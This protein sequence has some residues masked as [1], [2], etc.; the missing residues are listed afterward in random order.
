MTSLIQ[1]IGFLLICGLSSNAGE[2]N[3]KSALHTERDRYIRYHDSSEE[4]YDH[5]SDPNEC[6][7][8]AGQ[9]ES[10]GIR[11]ELA[12]WLPVHDIAPAKAGR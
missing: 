12:K 8:L 2:N 10:A 11:K 9:P 3:P 7:N 1:I 4:L 6:T 5:L